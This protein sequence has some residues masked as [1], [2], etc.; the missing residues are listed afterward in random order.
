MTGQCQERLIHLD[1]VLPNDFD[2]LIALWGDRFAA[3]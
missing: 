1:D 2:C 3:R